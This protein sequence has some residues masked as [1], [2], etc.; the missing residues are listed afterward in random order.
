MKLSEKQKTIQKKRKKLGIKIDRKLRD[1]I[2]GYLMSDGYISPSGSL[3][4][5]HSIKQRKFVEWLYEYFKILCTNTPIRTQN[6][7]DPRSNTKFTVCRFQTRNVLKGFRSM[8]YKKSKVGDKI[9]Y[10]KHLPSSLVCFFNS[11]FISV[12]FAGDGTKMTGQRGAKFEVTCFTPEERLQL[13]QLFKT[14]FNINAKIL[15][16]GKSEAGTPQWTLAIGTVDYE[17]FRTLITKIDL[18]PRLFPHK[19][20]KRA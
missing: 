2:H 9:Q 4:V 13:K 3:Q 5:Q 16:A 17:K 20:C 19:L 1:I 11:T 14:K 7:L 15:R 6:R 12:W 18:I 8:W 10:I